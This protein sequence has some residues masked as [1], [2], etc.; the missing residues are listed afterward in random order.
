MINTFSE[1]LVESKYTDAI[2][3]HGSLGRWLEE[4]ISDDP[5]LRQ[6]TSPFLTGIDPTIRLANA[7]DMLSDFDKQQVFDAV[8]R[9][10]KKT[11]ESSQSQAQ[12]QAQGGKNV[13][14]SFLK[15]ITSL[16]L[17]KVNKVS[18][19]G[20]IIYYETHECAEDLVTQS[21]SRFRS[22]M[23]IYTPRQGATVRMYFGIDSTLTL[24]YGVCD[25]SGQTVLGGF[26]LTK[27]SFAWLQTLRSLTSAQ[28]KADLFD[29]HWDDMLL[30]KKIF[31]FMSEYPLG[32]KDKMQPFFDGG[33]LCFSYY[34]VSKWDNGVIDAGEY[35]NIKTNIKTRLSSVQWH[36]RI[37]VRVSADN[38]SL[39]ICFRVK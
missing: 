12:A 3:Q 7:I 4:R 1:F 30:F 5:Y 14:K 17:S 26:A 34:G 19:P 37:L 11:N 27:G 6:V 10:M 16:G 13:L 31:K 2:R 24:T 15:C 18:K 36:D 32:D 39:S 9:K 25:P 23:T 20:F 28:L 38:F 29:L 21:V 8:V 22:L 33:T 35:A